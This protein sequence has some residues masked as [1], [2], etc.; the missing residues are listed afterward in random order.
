MDLH[1]YDCFGNASQ[2]SL[3][4]HRLQAQAP[5]PPVTR[6]PQALVPPPRGGGPHGP[7]A[8]ARVGLQVWGEAIQRLQAQGH[9][10][11]VG[12]WSL[13]TGVHAGGQAWADAQLEAF[14]QG[15][16]W[17]FWSYRKE[18]LVRGDSGGDTWSLRGV[19]DAGISLSQRPAPAPAAAWSSASL[20]ALMPQATAAGAWP[21]PHLAA[22]AWPAPALPP[23]RATPLLALVLVLLAVLA[24]AAALTRVRARARDAALTAA[25]TAAA[26]EREGHDCDYRR[27]EGV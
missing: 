2:K 22:G 17:F 25:G 14:G 5:P 8:A 6:T 16:G 20:A 1:L 21:A 18:G 10:V 23:A 7:K 15:M 9:R 12:E 27:L 19:V 24:A 3:Q 11:L 4:E 26:E 13:A